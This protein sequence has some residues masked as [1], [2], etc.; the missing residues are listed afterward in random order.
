MA[1]TAIEKKGNKARLSRRFQALAN[2]L[3][4]LDTALARPIMLSELI[5]PVVSL[6]Q[7]KAPRVTED[8]L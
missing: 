1:T 4:E 2:A 5:V 3:N 7:S 6:F 8:D